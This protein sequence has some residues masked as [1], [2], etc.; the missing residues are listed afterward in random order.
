MI[1]HIVMM[2][3]KESFDG[4]S[5]NEIIY[6]LKSKLETLPP[7][8]PQIKHYEVGID[9]NLINVSFDLV[10]I[11]EFENVND[12]EKYKF[13]PEHQQVGQYIHQ[14]T[15]TRAVVDFEF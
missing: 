5:K 1:K 11:S 13:N 7:I 4:K 6:E 15:D 14:V 12:L 3:V 8:I 9:L 10:L 2:R